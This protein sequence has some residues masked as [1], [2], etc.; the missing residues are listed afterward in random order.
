VLAG[1]ADWGVGRNRVRPKGGASM[2]SPCAEGG[3]EI[4]PPSYQESL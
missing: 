3:M 2:M 1:V 4:A